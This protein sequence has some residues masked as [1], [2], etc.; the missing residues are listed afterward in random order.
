MKIKE[1]LV[2]AQGQFKKN[3]IFSAGL[4]AE[5]LLLETMN[6][7][8]KISTSPFISSKK[9][10]K[11]TKF[12][13]RTKR[14]QYSGMLPSEKKDSGR[15]KIEI[16]KTWLYAHSEYG[17]NK[18]RQKK[19]ES[20]VQR[21]IKGEPIAYIVSR[22]EF[23]GLDF[24]VDKQVMVP[25]P[26]TETIVEKII[27]YAEQHKYFFVA[28]PHC[29]CCG[30]TELSLLKQSSLQK[31]LCCSASAR[32]QIIDIG[33]GSGCIAIALAKNIFHANPVRNFNRKLKYNRTLFSNGVKFYAVDISKG[34]IE[35]AKINA[36]KNKVFSRIKFLK[37]NLLEPI[38]KLKIKNNPT[39]I[40]AN[41]P[42]LKTKE[43]KKNIGL[44]YEPT[45]ALDGGEDG[46]EKIKKL[47]IQIKKI[48]FNIFECWIEINPEQTNDLIR[49][50]KKNLEEFTPLDM[51]LSNGVK[52]K[53]IKDISG[54]NRFLKIF[55]N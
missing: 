36:R 27:K 2:K 12:S 6:P 8:R 24:Y 19:F 17:L 48:N 55:K 13:Q 52:I 34:A 33:T 32:L 38:Q 50:I 39:I 35:T 54:Q 5:I 14:R 53:I 15:Q 22:K 10:F 43:I 20:F 25:R 51:E 9:I 26:E 45:V 1:A 7:V 3:K 23:F 41:L 29:K 4:D 31:C 21:R 28:C 37:G 18:T 42:Y 30:R 40:I 47:I 16:N 44:T 46:L 11:N 49:F